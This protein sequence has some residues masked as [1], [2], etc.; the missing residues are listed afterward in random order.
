MYNNNGYPSNAAYFNTLAALE[1]MDN[2]GNLQSTNAKIAY[3]NAQSMLKTCKTAY[4]KSYFSA[5]V[6][7]SQKI[8]LLANS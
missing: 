5:I 6:R 7:Y 1:A 2:Y 4:P 3:R 8:A